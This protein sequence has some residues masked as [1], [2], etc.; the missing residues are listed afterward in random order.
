MLQQRWWQQWL[1][2]WRIQQEACLDQTNTSLL[3]LSTETSF[4]NAMKMSTILKSL[5]DKVDMVAS[6]ISLASKR[7]SGVFDMVPLHNFLFCFHNLVLVF[8]G[9]ELVTVWGLM[10]ASAMCSHSP[11]WIAMH[12]V[13]VSEPNI[14]CNTFQFLFLF[15]SFGF[16]LDVN[17]VGLE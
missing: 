4:A 12:S 14:S 17:L 1:G 2:S 15:F 6:S 9:S 11:T 13:G 5:S 8:L 3:R 7:S 16:T 10:D